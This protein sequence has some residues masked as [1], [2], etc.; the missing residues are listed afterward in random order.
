MAKQP[1][2]TSTPKNNAKDAYRSKLNKPVM[3]PNMTK[4][5]KPMPKKK[6]K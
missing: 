3:R 1:I 4:T 6:S 2:D 5:M